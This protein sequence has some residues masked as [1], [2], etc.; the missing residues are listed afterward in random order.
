VPFWKPQDDLVETVKQYFRSRLCC[1]AFSLLAAILP[2]LACGQALAQDYLPPPQVKVLPVF[3]VPQDQ[4]P[5]AQKQISDLMRHL[6][7]TQTRYKEMLSG[8]A[9]FQL[10]EQPLIYTA[11][12]PLTYYR[13]Q[14]EGGAPQFAAEL[15]NKLKVSRWNCPYIFVAVIMNPHDNFPVGGGRPLNGGLN[16]GGGILIVSSYALEKPPNFQSTLQHELGHTFGLP[17]VDAYGYDMKNNP[18]IMSYNLRHHT[19]GFN[20]SKTPGILIP[21]DIR[22]LA[23]NKRVFPTLEFSAAKDVPAGYGLKKLFICLGPMLI[24]GQSD[25]IKATTASG[26]AFNTKAQNVVQK[27]IMPS[28]PEFGFNNQQMWH[29]A[30]TQN[31]WVSLTLT[32]PTEITLSGMGVHSQHS[33]QAHA[34]RAVRIEPQVRGNWHQVLQTN[35]TSIDQKVTFQPATAQ[36]WKINF[37]AGPSKWV[38]IRGLQ[39]YSGNEEVFPPMI[40]Y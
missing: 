13:Q 16:T 20:P 35:L 31:G 36:V 33:G 15:L 9:T 26:E 24:P 7:W 29:S 30:Q 39:F 37:Q 4:A 38:V 10:V 6:H 27:T 19:N 40:V 34:A 17:H 32:F 14:P 25:G 22:A 21:E 3:F 8:R 5:P 11:A 18:S 1:L 2:A 28:K 12:K 23:K